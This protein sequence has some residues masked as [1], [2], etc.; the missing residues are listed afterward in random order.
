M[1]ATRRQALRDYGAFDDPV[2]RA[3]RLLVECGQ[4]WERAA[5]KVAK[6]AALRFLRYFGM[7]DPAFFDRAPSYCRGSRR[8][9][10]QIESSTAVGDE[11]KA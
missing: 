5:P 10:A 7:V 2:D 3:Q 4:H 8:P 11:S 9:S 6:Q 1:P